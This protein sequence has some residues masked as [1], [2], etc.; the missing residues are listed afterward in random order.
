MFNLSFNEEYK[1]PS[2]TNI[3][4]SELLV[5]KKIITK[6]PKNQ[7]LKVLKK[8]SYNYDQ[9]INVYS[10]RKANKTCPFDSVH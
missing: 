9:I 2:D 8:K 10:L 3:I 4:K 5:R 7:S 1:I 6:K